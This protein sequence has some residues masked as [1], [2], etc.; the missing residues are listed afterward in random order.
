MSRATDA[1]TS[2]T[3]VEYASDRG[4]RS[5]T[6]KPS[7]G[8]SAILLTILLALVASGV[9]QQWAYS[10]RDR[11]VNANRPRGAAAP[12]RLANLDSFSLALLLGGLR[13]PLV[14]FL[15]TSS[16]TQKS[17]K[18]LESFDTQVEM[19]RL[20]Q[21]EFASVHLFQMWNKAYNVSVQMASLANKYASILDAIQYGELTDRSNPDD[22][23]IIMTI[24]TLYSDKLGN[25]AEKDY[26]R[27]RVRTETLPV[28]RLTMPA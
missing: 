27:K 6:L 17:E 9:F 2:S 14:M 22:L 11:A 12:S 21:P 8:R 15:W 20:L 18:D 19:I 5:R 10:F 16:E 26:Y 25:S 24:G 23:N 4:R 13:G 3:A 7:R 28:Y 1:S